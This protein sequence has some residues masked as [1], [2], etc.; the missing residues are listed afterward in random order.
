MRAS[1]LVWSLRR[2]SKLAFKG[3]EE[4]LAHGIVI[5]VTHRSH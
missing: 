1:A 5:G 2:S 3:R 4:A